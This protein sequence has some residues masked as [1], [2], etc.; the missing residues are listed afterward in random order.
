MKIFSRRLRGQEKML[1]LSSS[2]KT[3]LEN[4]DNHNMT[5]AC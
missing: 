3:S 4:N 1:W 2:I 5:R